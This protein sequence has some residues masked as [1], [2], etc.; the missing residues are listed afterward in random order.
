MVAGDESI[1][2]A[3]RPCL[4]PEPSVAIMSIPLILDRNAPS[5]N[6]QALL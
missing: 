4:D 2:P 6:V 1:T 5:M 3:E